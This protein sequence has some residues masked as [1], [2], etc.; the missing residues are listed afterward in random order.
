[1]GLEKLRA[2]FG[3]VADGQV[4]AGE[5]VVGAVFGGRV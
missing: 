1:V 4:E 3:F 5:F 2:G